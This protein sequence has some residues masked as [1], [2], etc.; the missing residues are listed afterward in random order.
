MT[1]NLGKKNTFWKL[2][3]EKSIDIPTVQRDYTYGSDDPKVK[4]T[5]KHLLDTIWEAFFGSKQENTLNFVYGN[6]N[7]RDA[8]VPLD[9]QQRLTTLFLLHLYAFWNKDWSSKQREKCE[10]ERNLG[11]FAYATRVSTENFCRNLIDFNGYNDSVNISEQLKN[12][13]FFVPSFAD[14]PS[15][16]SMLVVLDKIQDKFRVNRFDLWDLL[17]A[18]NCNVNFYS[19]DF[20]PFDFSDELYLKMNSRGKFLTRFEV[21]KS[22]LEYFIEKELHDKNLKNELAKKIDVDWGDFVWEEL[23]K[24]ITKVDSCLITLFT[25]LFAINYYLN[26]YVVD[27]ENDPLVVDFENDVDS[28]ISRHLGSIDKIRSLMSYM[29]CFVSISKKEGSFKKYWDKYFCSEE[30]VISREKRIRFWVFGKVNVLQAAMSKQLSYVEMLSLYAVYYANTVYNA[31]TSPDELFFDRCMRHIRNLSQN[32][33]NEIREDRMP[34]LL[35]D[36]RIIFD[37][38]LTNT[39][40]KGFNNYQ[41]KE[42]QEKERNIA[43]WEQ[44]YTYENHELLRGALTLFAEKAGNVDFSAANLPAI[45]DVLKKFEH[46]FGNDSNSKFLETRGAL[47]TYGDISQPIARHPDRHFLGCQYMSWRVLLLKSGQ[48]IGQEKIINVLKNV[49]LAVPFAAKKS[50]TNEL[51]YYLSKYAAYTNIA[52]NS[53]NYG[54]YVIEDNAKPLEVIALQ[55]TKHSD[56]NVEKRLLNHILERTWTQSRFAGNE[57]NSHIALEK[58]STSKIRVKNICEIGIKQDGWEIIEKNSSGVIATLT[59]KGYSFSGNV[60]TVPPN[61]DYIEFAQKLIDIIV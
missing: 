8:F 34:L 60:C 22:K 53:V 35:E 7:K 2:I 36:V 26:D 45:L 48:R 44:V 10:A 14:D 3:Q 9:G 41:W 42:E 61:Q 19:L 43:S 6:K 33:D 31:T 1:I 58:R 18:D 37:N 20:G 5:C 49:N 11:K 29:D 16:A 51:G 50:N 28:V 32:G 21:F 52:Y 57:Q 46:V 25:N 59:Q 13:A 47:M 38:K 30:T 17:V 39:P 56:S 23:G 4:R 54:Y 55:S 24:D 15:I 40:Q 27:E 12:Q